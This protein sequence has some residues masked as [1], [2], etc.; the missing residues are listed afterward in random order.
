MEVDDGSEARGNEKLSSRVESLGVFCD[1]FRISF[2]DSRR[3]RVL[4]SDAFEIF[5]VVVAFGSGG[6]GEA[7]GGDAGRSA[8]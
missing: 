5:F 6:E 2:H 3:S 1:A 4:S 7:V 8:R